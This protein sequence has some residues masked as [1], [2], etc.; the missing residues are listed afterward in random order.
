MYVECG[1]GAC[2]IALT[3]NNVQDLLNQVSGI[4][5]QLQG[6]PQTARVLDVLDCGWAARLASLPAGATTADARHGWW[7]NPSQSVSRTPWGALPPVST[8]GSIA[9]SYE[10][11]VALS[12]YDQLRVQGI[13]I[14]A[15]P[16]RGTDAFTDRQLRSLAGEA[17]CAPQMLSVAFAFYM[18]PFAP[19]WRNAS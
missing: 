1:T 9:Y 7:C 12:G 13:P 8:I 2:K 11:D 5:A 4:N 3:A 19:W 16:Q 6:C 14:H 18:N 15:A 17:F 10:Y